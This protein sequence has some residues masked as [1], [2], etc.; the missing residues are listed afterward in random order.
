M[1]TTHFTGRSTVGREDRLVRGCVAFSLVLMAL[2]V[3][4]AAEGVVLSGFVLLAIGGYFTI[5]AVTGWDPVYLRFGIDTRGD[6]ELAEE[7]GDDRRPQ[8]GEA[9]ASL[10]GLRHQE[11][12]ANEQP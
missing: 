4:L 10:L 8:S 5:T 6:D 2:F 9:V 1:G 11:S 12:V 7:A 3:V